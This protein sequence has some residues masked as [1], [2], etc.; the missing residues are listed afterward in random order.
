MN[1][2]T[3]G[4]VLTTRENCTFIENTKSEFRNS[5]QILNHN[6]QMFKTKNKIT[7]LFRS[8]ELS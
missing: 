6:I 5:K 7:G 3:T 1:V 4:E 8:M 2:G